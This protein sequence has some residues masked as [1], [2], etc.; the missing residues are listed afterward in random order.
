MTLDSL[1]FLPCLLKGLP[2]RP[3]SGTEKVHERVIGLGRAFS[4][5]R[6]VSVGR[7]VSDIRRSD[8]AGRFVPSEEIASV[9]DADCE[10]G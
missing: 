2:G 10:G 3:N 9:H 6:L 4:V 5:D 1:F 8:S 7:A